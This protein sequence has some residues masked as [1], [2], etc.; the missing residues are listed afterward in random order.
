VRKRHL[1]AGLWLVCAIAVHVAV[2][3]AGFFV[4]VG[5]AGVSP[6]QATVAATMAVAPLLILLITEFRWPSRSRPVVWPRRSIAISL[7]QALVLGVGTVPLPQPDLSGGALAALVAAPLLQ[8]GP[9]ILASR[10]LRFPLTPELGATD[11][12]VQAR[13]RSHQPGIPDWLSQDEVTLNEWE[14]LVKL[15]P[16]V[17]SAFLVRIPLL[18]IEDVSAR[19]AVPQDSPWIT[20]AK[21]HV[22]VVPAGDVVVVQRRDGTLVLPV[23]LAEEFAATARARVD[24]ANSL[25]ASVRRP[26]HGPK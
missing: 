5:R 7:A 24:R 16:S 21:S 25:A 2:M 3:V 23:R 15:R 17:S 19:S 22:Y 12:E 4:I 8:V 26:L 20:V 1:R 10:A 14:L 11:V 9:A 13:I 6:I 18:D